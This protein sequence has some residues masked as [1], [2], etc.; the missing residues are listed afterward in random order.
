[1]KTKD[2]IK[3]DY[4]TIAQVKTIP[5]VINEWIQCDADYTFDNLL[6]DQTKMYA[7]HCTKSNKPEVIKIER[8]EWTG[9]Y[10]GRKNDYNSDIT[11]WVT[12]I[13][14][15]GNDH[16]VRLSYD[17]LDSMIMTAETGCSGSVREPY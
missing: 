8:L 12:A 13:V 4:L 7:T 5:N 14:D 9:N 11:V 1:M 15:L 3:N 16:I 2:I 10:N 17:L 6:D